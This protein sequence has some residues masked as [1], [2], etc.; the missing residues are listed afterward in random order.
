MSL[1]RI[2]QESPSCQSEAEEKYERWKD[3][4]PFPGI[5]E[6]LLNCS[7]L[8]SYVAKTGMLF[9]FDPSDA[10]LKMAT[11]SF[12][13]GG[14]VVRWPDEKGDWHVND[15]S[16]GEE[17]IVPSN[18]ITYVTLKPYIRL[19]N[20]I[21]LRFNLRIDNVYRG[22]LLGTGPVIDP[23]Y[24]GWL[25]IPLHNLTNNEYRFQGGERMIWVEF[26]KISNHDDWSEEEQKEYEGRVTDIKRP[27]EPPEEER[28]VKHH[29]KEA[30]EGQPDVDRV[31]S[32]I[33]SSLQRA[34]NA[35]EKAKE[36]ATEAGDRADDAESRVQNLVSSTA[37]ATV[38]S[39]AVVVLGVG[40]FFSVVN[41]YHIEVENLNRKV[42]SLEVQVEKYR[43]ED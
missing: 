40:A 6:S 8:C 36:A 25:S 18:S 5:S 28:N 20:Y 16:D 24:E 11:Y 31:R 3:K 37:L 33:G 15:V 39:L 43:D 30:L 35:S 41:S 10:K 13:I 7:D 23:G 2:K 12:E 1:Y 19:P 26:T 22:L 27:Y 34:R 9:P 42:D 14:K 38:L 32:S 21:A 17:F 29:L 4:D